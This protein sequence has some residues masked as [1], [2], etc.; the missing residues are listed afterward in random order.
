MGILDKF[1]NMSAN[2]FKYNRLKD[3]FEPRT[4]GK[5]GYQP[6]KVPNDS[7]KLATMFDVDHVVPS[8]WGGIDHPRNMVVMHRTMNRS[9]RDSLPETKW[10]YLEQRSAGILRKVAIFA[11]EVYGSKQVQAAVADYIRNDM[12]MI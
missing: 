3:F 5:Q 9:F 7:G 1:L 4:D 6:K 8:R 11:R 10:Y 2:N 12:K